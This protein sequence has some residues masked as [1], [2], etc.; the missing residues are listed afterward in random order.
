MPRARPIMRQPPSHDT[1]CPIPPA[2]LIDAPVLPFRR[3]HS[4][5]APE[6]GSTTRGSTLGG[7]HRLTPLRGPFGDVCRVQPD[8]ADQRGSH[9]VLESQAEEEQAGRFGNDA[10]HVA[11]KSG[12][13]EDRQIDPT[14]VW[15]EAGAPDDDARL[16]HLAA[17]DRKPAALRVQP[18][19]ATDSR[20]NEILL[21]D[22]DQRVTAGRRLTTESPAETSVQGG[23]R[24][25]W[26]DPVEDVTAEDAPR[27]V[28]CVAAGQPHLAMA[29]ELERDLRAG[30][31]GADDQNGSVRQRERIAIAARVELYDRSR[32]A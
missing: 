17:T 18:S 14:V 5:P 25:H 6:N 30:V 24:Q 19:D 23:A 13:I 8:A 15:R 7:K 31:A 3:P 27:Q 1:N 28:A 32:D 22:T 2:V 20:R 12:F 29:R 26:P 16:E 9:P 10:A 11:R 4:T 21:R